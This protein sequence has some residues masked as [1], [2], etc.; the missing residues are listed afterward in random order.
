MG[1]IK[2]PIRYF[3]GLTQEHDIDV[4]KVALA[5]GGVA[6]LLKSHANYELTSTIQ[7]A[8]LVRQ[9]AIRERPTS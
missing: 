2:E 6:Y 1:S 8:M 9:T 4:R 3:R 7:T 5:A